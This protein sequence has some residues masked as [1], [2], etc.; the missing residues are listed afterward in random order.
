MY[1]K[2]IKEASGSNDNKVKQAVAENVILAQKILKLEENLRTA[3]VTILH[4][5]EELEELIK[6]Y[7]TL[8]MQHQ[9][10]SKEAEKLNEYARYN[11]KQVRQFSFKRSN[12]L[13]SILST[14]S[15][16]CKQ[17]K[18]ELEFIKK[19]YKEELKIMLK[20]IESTFSD[21]STKW[22]WVNYKI[23]EEW[24]KQIRE[25]SRKA[26][27]DVHNQANR[28]KEE[29][30]S[31]LESLNRKC[32]IGEEKYNDIQWNLEES[33]SKI[34]QLTYKLEEWESKLHQKEKKIEICENKLNQ[35]EE[36]IDSYFSENINDLKKEFDKQNEINEIEDQ[37]KIHKM[38]V[39]TNKKIEKLKN[40]IEEMQRVHYEEKL[41]VKEEYQDKI[42]TLFKE[43]YTN[44]QR[45]SEADSEIEILR[46]KTTLLEQETERFKTVIKSVL[47]ETNIEISED[48]NIE[49][50][51]HSLITRFKES[52]RMI[53]KIKQD[54]ND[55]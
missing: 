2:K 49:Q 53:D 3:R 41:K 5:D 16:K 43:S 13:K 44:I 18:N 51:L 17:F 9:E 42:D 50:S 19:W 29:F 11:G 25:V 37:S 10:I 39:M 26:D 20:Y 6:E 7:D 32:E 55:K 27:E 36:E 22:N 23:K 34:E 54:N 14:V 45:L 38:K 21:I 1:E 30:A 31:K 33:V 15:S 4:K 8:K 48:Q 24:L 12:T 35:Y 28:L 47:N 46:N 52:E 40:K